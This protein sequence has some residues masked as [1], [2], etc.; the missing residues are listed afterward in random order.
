MPRVS[1]LQTGV[2]IFEVHRG[3]LN[4]RAQNLI[5][6]RQLADGVD[7]A[8]WLHHLREGDYSRWME[9]AIKDSELAEA[10]HKI[11]QQSSLSPQESRQGIAHAIEERYTL[12]AGGM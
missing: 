6:F 9:M 2:F 1:C 5:L 12:P 4:L 3:N 7:D 10:V 11:E 8:T